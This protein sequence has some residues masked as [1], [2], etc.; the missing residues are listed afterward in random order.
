MGSFNWAGFIDLY[1][2]YFE[3]SGSFSFGSFSFGSFNF[4]SFGF[5]SFGFGSYD[6]QGSYIPL[7]IGLTA[8]IAGEPLNM[9][10]YGIDLI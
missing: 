2:K 1:Y 8:L 3:K 10:G 5:G 4:G 6:A 7:P 9:F